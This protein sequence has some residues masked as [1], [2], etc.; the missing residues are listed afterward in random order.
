MLPT[1]TCIAY[2]TVMAEASEPRDSISGE[3]RS[4]RAVDHLELTSMASAGTR[5][6]CLLSFDVVTVHVSR[7]SYICKYKCEAF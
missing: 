7:P 6:M 2:T 1:P 3:P 4:S 5:I